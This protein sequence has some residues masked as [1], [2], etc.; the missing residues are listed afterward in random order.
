MKQMEVEH[1]A[2]I[3]SLEGDGI[4]RYID[5]DAAAP[6]PVP[7]KKK[8]K[9]TQQSSASL[10]ASTAATVYTVSTAGTTATTTTP[11]PVTAPRKIYFRANEDNNSY[12]ISYVS[13]DNNTVL[14]LQHLKNLLVEANA[15]PKSSRVIFSSGDARLAF[16]TLLNDCL[17]DNTFANPLL[18]TVQ[19][20]AIVAP[21]QGGRSTG[22]S[23]CVL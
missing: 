18:V 10:A 14:T 12:A 4:N 2:A 11:A 3:V 23:R 1:D 9:P 20:M 19:T 6:V 5:G 21:R 7:R 16:T 17:L 13:I 8:K 15:W 22:K